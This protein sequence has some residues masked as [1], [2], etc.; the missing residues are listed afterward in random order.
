MFKTKAQLLR[1]DEFI[2]AGLDLIESTAIKDVPERYPIFDEIYGI[3]KKYEN[4]RYLTHI[5]A[6]E[7]LNEFDTMIKK[8]NSTYKDQDGLCLIN[9]K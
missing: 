1:D 7:Y 5:H 3:A 8:F 4:S 6:R 2:I 9:I